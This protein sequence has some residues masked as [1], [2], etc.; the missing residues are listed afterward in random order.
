[1]GNIFKIYHLKDEALL[2]LYTR[3]DK[4]LRPMPKKSDGTIDQ[5]CAGLI[6]NNI[7]ALRHAFLSGVY[8]IEF[9]SETA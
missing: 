2:D 1:M 7:D 8:A 5:Y 3:L 9:S 6:N 4:D